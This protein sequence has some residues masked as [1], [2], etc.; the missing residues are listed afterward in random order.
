MKAESATEN[1]LNFQTLELF[2]SHHNHDNFRFIHKSMI[3]FLL[4]GRSTNCPFAQLQS[5][6]QLTIYRLDLATRSN[7]S[8][9]LMAYEF[10]EPFAALINSSARHSAIDLTFRKEASLA[11]MV[12]KAI[13]WLTLRSGETSTACRLTVPAEPI[14]VLSSLGPQLTIA[15]TA[16]WIGFWSV[17]I[18][19]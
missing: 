17:R 4:S 1:I 12:I 3:C 19:I 9:F 10:D 2:F 13:A 15:S 6:H 18:W 8:F 16:I 14:L 7:S 11:P 5:F